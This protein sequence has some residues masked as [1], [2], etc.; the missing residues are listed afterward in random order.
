ME[1]FYR[2][3]ESGTKEVISKRK[4][5]FRPGLSFSFLSFSFFFFGA[6]EAKS[7]GFIMQI[8]SLVLIRKFQMTV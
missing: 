4:D 1:G 5:C 7:R 8:A 2:Q 3:K 6:R